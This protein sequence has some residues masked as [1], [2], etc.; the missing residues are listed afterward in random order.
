MGNACCVDQKEGKVVEVN[1]AIEEAPAKTAVVASEPA[2]SDAV[3]D[4]FAPQAAM[5][6]EPE[7]IR[8]ASAPK[9][10]AKF[11]SV[12]YLSTDGQE[13]GE[14]T[15]DGTLLSTS[16]PSTQCKKLPGGTLDINGIAVDV[17]AGRDGELMLAWPDGTFWTKQ[18]PGAKGEF[19]EYF[20][21]WHRKSDGKMMAKI[22]ADGKVQW[23]H[24]EEAED[25]MNVQRGPARA[26]S[27]SRQS[28][29]ESGRASSTAGNSRKSYATTSEIAPGAISQLS[30]VSA[31]GGKVS[32]KLE[33]GG[34][35]YMIEVLSGG[36]FQFTTEPFKGMQWVRKASAV[37]HDAV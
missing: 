1:E 6:K 36:V 17:I 35:E 26:S 11:A 13:V 9:E 25:A 10:F 5:L 7:P 19:E 37:I 18:K 12:W 21:V 15:A 4:P 3:P 23:M 16:A 29:K 8:E 14:I 34:K 33:N 22:E 32:L 31:S 28:G 20:G 30:K 27:V 2:Q 24:T